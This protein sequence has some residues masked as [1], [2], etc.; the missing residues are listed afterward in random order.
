MPAETPSLGVTLSLGV[1]GR[2]HGVRGELV[3]RPHNPQGVRL[4]ALRTPFDA[5]IGAVANPRSDGPPDSTAGFTPVRI[6]GARRFGE[7]SLVRLDGVTDRDVAAG[8][9]NRELRVPRAVL[10]ALAPG[11]FYVS[12]LIG[13]TVVDQAARAR[14]RVVGVYWNG[15]QDVLVIAD[16]DG[17]E[18]LVPALPDFLREVDLDGQRVVIDDHE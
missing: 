3:F 9:T 18:L 14:G 8:F 11:E 7:E 16:Q 10:P 17:A 2:P 15:C 4:E 1:L 6:L 13:A 5:A 12:D